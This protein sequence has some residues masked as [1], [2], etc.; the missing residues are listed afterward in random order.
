MSL[1]SKLRLIWLPPIFLTENVTFS[2]P[3][4]NVSNQKPQLIRQLLSYYSI[5]QNVRLYLRIKHFWSNVIF[6]ASISNSRLNFCAMFCIIYLVH[7]ILNKYFF[8]IF[9]YI[10]PILISSEF[11][12][13][14]L[15]SKLL[16]SIIILK[17]VRNEG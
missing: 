9:V 12:A 17:I 14:I 10:I 16:K 11:G 7:I 4:K 2:P 8:C 15:I 6:T 5:I 13:V 1:S 3:L